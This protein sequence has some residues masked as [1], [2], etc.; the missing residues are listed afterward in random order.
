LFGPV[1]VLTRL[2]VACRPEPSWELVD[3][4]ARRSPVV[5][6]YRHLVRLLDAGRDAVHGSQEQRE[7]RPPEVDAI[8]AWARN[9]G[10]VRT[11][12]G[13]LVATKKGRAIDRHAVDLAFASVDV[14]NAVGPVRLLLGHDFGHLVQHWVDH[15]WMTLLATVVANGGPM[16]EE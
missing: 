14:M 4:S 16:L 2:D 3:A 6:R 7:E 9:V 1:P 15:R 11:S 12:G 8:V 5:D 13:A 10:V